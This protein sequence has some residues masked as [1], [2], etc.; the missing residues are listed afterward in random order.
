MRAPWDPP[1]E[2]GKTTSEVPTEAKAAPWEKPV[3]A[4]AAPWE[5]PADTTPKPDELGRYDANKQ[6]KSED[7]LPPEEQAQIEREYGISSEMGNIEYA[8]RLGKRAL[9]EAGIGLEQSWGGLKRFGNDI[10]GLDNSDNQKN[11]DHLDAVSKTLGSPESHA[12]R[13]VEGAVSSI[14]QQ[15]PLIAGGF[16]TAA[17]APVVGVAALAGEAAIGATV[18]TGMFMQSFGQT[19]DDSRREGL[20]LKDSTIRSGAFGLLEV[21]GEKFGLGAE[22]KAIKA[23]AKGV[24]TK[25]LAGYFAKALAKEV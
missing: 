16:A 21:V 22:I 5:K 7:K 8:G 23:S 24:P 3:Q 9:K 6:G 15:V 20:D 2:S 25:E 12:A 10:L 4:Q 14:I 13:I 17:A 11:L 19:Y 1:E 18:L